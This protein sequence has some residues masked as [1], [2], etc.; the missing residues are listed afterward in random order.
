MIYQWQLA[1]ADSWH[2]SEKV[3]VLQMS[4]IDTAC[5]ITQ[6]STPQQCISKEL[7]LYF[8]YTSF[9]KQLYTAPS[10][11][12]PSSLIILTKKCETLIRKTRLRDCKLSV[13]RVSKL[14]ILFFFIVLNCF[15]FK[16][17]WY[18]S[19]KR[20]LSIGSSISLAI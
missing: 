2:Y 15:S 8:K 10:L 17:A 12:N 11:I 1:E 9:T 7:T 13:K 5:N 6:I 19:R 20:D 3:T 14:K 4:E 16:E 18:K